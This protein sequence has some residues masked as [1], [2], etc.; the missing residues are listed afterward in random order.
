[1][2][3]LTI[4]SST[5]EGYTLKFLCDFD[6]NGK[7]IQ[8][9]R[10]N[11]CYCYG[12]CPEYC[13]MKQAFELLAAYEDTGLTPDEIKTLQENDA[14]R[15]KTQIPQKPILTTECIGFTN[16][17]LACECPN[18]HKDI[19]KAGWANYCYHCGQALDWELQ[20]KDGE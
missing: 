18:C 3:K 17:I 19:I 7:I 9:N 13:E 4:K 12:N 11:E 10:C 1:M 6:N 5:V 14:C 16:H 8:E 2:E 20:G 15:N